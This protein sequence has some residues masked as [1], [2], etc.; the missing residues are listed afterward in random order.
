MQ[1]VLYIKGG[2]VL[3]SLCCKPADSFIVQP[4][5]FGTEQSI[6]NMSQLS[7]AETVRVNLWKLGNFQNGN[8]K[9]EEL[10]I[11]VTVHSNRFLFK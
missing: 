1:N 11:H 2:P 5:Y 4:E 9:M 3:L 8:D 7:S 10:Y 6:Q